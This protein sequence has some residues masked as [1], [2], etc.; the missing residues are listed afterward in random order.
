MPSDQEVFQN[1]MNQGH[2]AVWDQDW[3]VAEKYYRKALEIMP[4]QTIALTSLGLALF[5]QK[6]FDEALIFYTKAAQLSPNEPLAYEKMARIYARMGQVKKAIAA[7]LQAGEQYLKIRDADKS[8]ENYINAIN[9]QPDH[10]NARSRLALVYDRMGRT[11]NAVIEYLAVASILQ[12]SGSLT[13][14]SQAIDHCLKINPTNEAAIKARQML[15]KN[16]LLPE[17]TRP[18][19]V[20]ASVRMAEVHQM[21]EPIEKTK[22]NLDPIEETHQKAL[23]EL[24][25]L[26]FD[27]DETDIPI[28]GQTTGLLKRGKLVDPEAITLHLGQA[29]DAL[30]R[31]NNDQAIRE[32]EKAQ[33]AGLSHPVISFEL[34]LL[35]E[36]NDSNKALRHLYQAI[37]NGEYALGSYLKIGQIQ[38]R[39]S[40]YK[41]AAVAYLRALH[42]ADAQTVSQNQAKGLYRLYEPI[43]E[44]QSQQTD[45]D[46]LERLCE[47]IASQLIRPDWRGFL[48]IARQQ[49]PSASLD[50]PPTPLAEMLLETNSGQIIEAI[51]AIQRMADDN[52]IGSALEEAYLSL[53]Y[54]P[55]YLPMH[56]QIGELLAKEGMTQEAVS[57]FILVAR[58]Y[59]LQGEAAQAIGLLNRVIQI[60]P[61]DQSVRAFLIELLISQNLLEDAIQQSMAL[62]RNYEYL[63]DFTKMRK[64]YQDTLRLAQRSKAGSDWSLKILYEIADIDMQRLDWHQAVRVFEQIRTMEPNDSTARAKLVDLNFRLRE[65]NVAL[66]ELDSFV[67]NLESTGEVDE[68]ITFVQSIIADW[69]EKAELRRF[70]AEL[71]ARN[72]RVSL[73]IEQLDMVAST[74]LDSKNTPGAIKALERIISLNP[75]NIAE[76]QAALGKLRGQ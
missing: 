24:A 13:K 10:L 41:D 54:A 1:N 65:D 43:I 73:A 60:A 35:M 48:K 9:L 63:A 44:A 74:M 71:Y 67:N 2:S 57:K 46:K 51:A 5:E 8:I 42:L 16:Q 49:I 36:D 55:T 33:D 40:N 30:T 47:I 15:D 70:L 37:R 69:E 25:S 6:K 3:E 38:A 7:S 32:L 39:S 64:I 27:G 17:P 31:K 21:E 23:V 76:Y 12:R 58:L 45:Q 53:Q 52:K 28:P 26:L 62:A 19:G 75:P 72:K 20:T 11:E 66:A 29:I 34:G 22:A 68:A 56:I 61:M 14:A 18:E 4:D 50:A 59:Q